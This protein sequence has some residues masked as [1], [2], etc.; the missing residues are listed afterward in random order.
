MQILLLAAAISAIVL[1]GETSFLSQES[2][3]QRTTDTTQISKEGEPT[4][5]STGSLFVG[6]IIRTF[7]GS[8]TVKQKQQKQKQVRGTL[9]S[10]F[11]ILA[12]SCD[13][14]AVVTTIWEPTDGVKSVASLPDW[15][16]VIVGDTKT[17]ANY[18]QLAGLENDD[19]VVYLSPEDQ[20]KIPSAFVKMM[21]FRSFA[22][23]NIGYLFAI[24]HGAQ[25]IYDFDD[26]NVLK[27]SGWQD[28]AYISPMTARTSSQLSSSVFVRSL[29]SLS[30]P[31]K[32]PSSLGF[33]PLP[34]M[35]PTVS[36]VWPRGFPLEAIQD[37]LTT[38]EDAGIVPAS[39]NISSIG[40]IQ[41]VCDG[42]PDMDAI[43]R[44]T[45]TLPIHFDNSPRASQLL[46]P[47]GLYAPYNAQ[48]TVHMNSAFWGLFLPFTV[49]GRVT[50]IWRSYFTQKF[51]HEMNLALIYAPPLVTH[52]RTP[53]NYIADMQAENDLYMKT[54]KL[55]EF[56]SG[57][58]AAEKDLPSRLEK[59]YIDLY[60]RSYI[61]LQD[62]EAMQEWIFAL[63]DI[64]YEFPQLPGE[65]EYK[66]SSENMQSYPPELQGQPFLSFPTYN[67]GGSNGEQTYKQFLDS[68][69][70]KGLEDDWSTWL[71]GKEHAPDRP[72]RT[73]IKLIVMLKDEW[74]LIKK[75]V[76]YHGE[77]IGFDNL[78]ILDGS[79]DL[80]CISFLMDA[81]DRLG[82]NV[83]FTPANLNEL[84]GEMTNVAVSLAASSDFI[85]KMDADEY[86]TLHTG[87]EGCRSSGKDANNTDCTLSPFGLE[88][89]L[90]NMDNLG[91]IADGSRLKIGYVS[92]TVPDRQLCE[93]GQGDDIGHYPMGAVAPTDF[94]TVYDSRTLE[95]I[96]L[97]GHR[98]YFLGPF[99][100]GNIRAGHSTPLSIIHAHG[101]C[102]Q[103]EIDNCRKA[104]ISHGYINESDES[105]AARQ[106]LITYM[107]KAS[108]V[109]SGAQ[110][111]VSSGH[112][113]SFY[114]QYLSGC[115]ATTPDGFYIGTGIKRNLDFGSYLDAAMLKYNGNVLP[116]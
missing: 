108:D 54:G 45:R 83:I 101:R 113:V 10:S 71:A 110:F 11:P 80:K 29:P 76:L 55:L 107:K 24:R 32:R 111:P 82:A 96:D 74:P 56:L 5:G 42:D 2:P 48:A 62:V 95:K 60:E 63:L 3:T 94:K 38:G 12:K 72:K 51:L 66:N 105:E 53:H 89:Y 13:Q 33:N 58:S 103:H 92:S 70:R 73:V 78:Y 102:L 64:G 7:S 23:K 75:W 99:N 93:A 27:E 31:T 16:L 52:T 15:C 68:E 115:P 4:V 49:P 30:D 17:P 86:L 116:A 44:L 25:V 57:W 84:A 21:P 104:C 106:K 8:W 47:A 18:L 26:D 98:G 85:I 59:L 22:R 41:A 50:D 109:C 40:V 112:K 100:T 69:G 6:D 81:R 36:Q 14:W 77:L 114:L 37:P 34:L 39:L 91:S 90:Q 46:V 65:N 88:E 35:K 79:T 87:E 61:G 9:V 43:F 20:K 97:G 19:R 28:G 1:Y 67:L